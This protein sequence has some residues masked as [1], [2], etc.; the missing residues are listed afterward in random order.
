MSTAEGETKNLHFIREMIEEDMRTNKYDGKVVTRFPPEPNGYLHIGHAKAIC[1]DFGMAKEYGGRCHLRFDDTN[2]STEETE[3]VDSIQADVRWLGFDWGEDLYYASSYFDQMYAF[4]EELI[5]KDLAYVCTLSPDE[6]KAYRGIPTEPGKAS[7]GR[8]RSIEENLDLFRRMRAGEF[9]D[10]AYVLRAKIDMASPNLHMRDPALYRIKHC[11]HHRTGDAWCIYPMYDFAHCLEDAIEG[12]THS[13][14]TLEFEVHRPLY[15]WIINNVSV[16]GKPEQTEF[17]RLNLSYTIMSKRKLQQL[18]REKLVNGWDD[19]RMP[20][21]AGL[22]RRGYTPEAI[23]TF[24]ET[25]GVTKFNSL[26]DMALLEHCLRDD[27]NK[28]AYRVMGVMDP[29]KLVIDNFP[30]G[31]TEWFDAVNNPEDASA[32]MRKVP[33]TKD[34]YIERHDF[35]ENPPKKFFRLSPGNEVRLRYACIVRCESVVKNDDGEIVEI[36]CTWDPESHGGTAPDGRKVRGTIH[37]VSAVHFVPAEIRLY[38][39]LFDKENPADEKDGSPF[40]DHLN[41]E[42]LKCVAA[43]MEPSIKGAAP[44]THYQ[45]E[46]IGYFNVDLDSTSEAPVFNRTVTLRDSWGRKTGQ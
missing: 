6:F 44:L 35:M 3:Y 25:I 34:L 17:A 22:R 12:I 15:D 14:C 20:T 38:D 23:R 36:H 42:S 39:R 29:V 11:A 18:V 32:G 26:T 10:G 9:P 37:W 40:T 24:C 28:R 7:P 8:S 13:L 1:L 41:L 46:R 43:L 2:P 30:E 21:L 5:N 27:L 4:A 19:P 33:F 45:F 31:E 16:A